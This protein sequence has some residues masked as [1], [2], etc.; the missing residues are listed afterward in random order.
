MN[1]STQIQMKGLGLKEKWYKLAKVAQPVSGWEGRRGPS[2][3]RVQI[4]SYLALSCDYC[5]FSPAASAVTVTLWLFLVLYQ[6]P[7]LARPGA[8]HWA[9][10]SSLRPHFCTPSHLPA[11]RPHHSPAAGPSHSPQS[12]TAMLP[13]LQGC[14]R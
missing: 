4:L 9:P 1:A 6:A 5:S 14:S 8:R 13:L 3:F 11:I 7:G 12:V 2:D 10:A